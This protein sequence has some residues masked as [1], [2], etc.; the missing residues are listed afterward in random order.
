VVEVRAGAEA[1]VGGGGG[2]GGGITSGV[3]FIGGISVSRGS[4]EP[5]I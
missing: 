4:E 2:G 1:I 5:L 3:I